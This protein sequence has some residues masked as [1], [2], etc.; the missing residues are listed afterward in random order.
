MNESPLVIVAMGTTGAGKS[1]IGKLLADRL[2]WRFVDG[3]G[4]HPP[5]NIEKMRAGQSLDDAD[6]EPWLRSLRDAIEGW[7]ESGKS[8]VLACSA[9]K[10]R[11][12]ERLGANASVVFVYLKGTET[13]L[14]RRIDSRE[15]H[16]AKADL[17]ASQFEALEEPG[18]DEPAIH[19]S[20]S[21]TPEQIVQDVIR[22]L[23]LTTT[24]ANNAWH[25][26]TKES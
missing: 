22:R 15:G 6:R 19:V 9:L 13:E 11:Y 18:Q 1:T 25:I 10:R 26:A 23:C 16:F 2:G 5:A 20:A 3:D 12:R 14:R 8:V 7:L 17:L 21:E 24:S 4:Y